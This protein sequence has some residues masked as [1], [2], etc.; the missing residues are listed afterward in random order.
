M[1]HW[2][3][4]EQQ[5]SWRTF[6]F[7]QRRLNAAL[8]RQLLTDSDLSIPDFE[9]LVLLTDV[10]DGKLRITDMAQALDWE[11]SR[12]SHHLKRMGQRGLIGRAD[13]DDDGRGSY[14]VVTDEGR[15]VIEAAAPGHVNAVRHMVVDALGASELATLAK[16]AAKIDAAVDDFET[17]GEV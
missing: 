1:T 9:V 8:A 3:T 17:T 5:T 15:R 4:D 10:P 2:L 16:L 6:M 13:C 14:A 7:A 12:L 11:R